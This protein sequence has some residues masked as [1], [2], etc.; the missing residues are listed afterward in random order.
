MWLGLCVRA[1]RGETDFV[2]DCIKTQSEFLLLECQSTY[3]LFR[4]GWC[5]ATP[6]KTLFGKIAMEIRDR[7]K[8]R[9]LFSI[10][11]QNWPTGRS[12][13]ANLYEIDGRAK[14]RSG[15]G[16]DPCRGPK[17]LHTSAQRRRAGTAPILH[18]STPSLCTSWLLGCICPLNRPAW[19]ET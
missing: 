15:A 4:H 17:R 2:R 7:F 10:S 18:L 9:E 14:A 13:E 3:A 19:Q 1:Q 16:S 8:E 12:E 6:G 11:T 5:S